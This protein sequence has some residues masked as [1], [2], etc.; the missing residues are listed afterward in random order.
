MY[1][2]SST[3]KTEKYR[4]YVYLEMIFFF[5]FCVPQPL[6]TEYGRKTITKLKLQEIMF[7]CMMPCLRKSLPFFDFFTLGY[8]LEDIEH[9][10]FLFYWNKTKKGKFCEKKLVRVGK[11]SQILDTLTRPEKSFT[12]QIE[13][14]NK[15]SNFS[16]LSLLY[17]SRVGQKKVG[18]FKGQSFSFLVSLCRVLFFWIQQFQTFFRGY[19]IWGKINSHI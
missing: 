9:K 11:N 19:I 14:D 7:I 12:C 1:T 10:W 6:S 13:L 3:P 18:L 2:F 8:I 5:V 16:S 15:S 4:Y 17:K